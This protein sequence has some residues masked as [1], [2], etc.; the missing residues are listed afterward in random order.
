MLRDNRGLQTGFQKKASSLSIGGNLLAHTEM[1]YWEVEKQV[2]ILRQNNVQ[3][4]W[5]CAESHLAVAELARST[6]GVIVIV[7]THTWPKVICFQRVTLQWVCGRVQEVIYCTAVLNWNFE[8]NGRTLHLLP[9]PSSC[10]AKAH[11]PWLHSCLNIRILHKPLLGKIEYAGAE[12]DLCPPTRAMK[13]SF[14]Y[15]VNNEEH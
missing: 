6:R 1:V 5:S 14:T 13:C 12:N 3:K 7:D 4:W 9:A 10:H 11:F 15:S 8:D 2:M